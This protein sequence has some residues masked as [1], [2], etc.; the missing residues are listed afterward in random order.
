MTGEVL[1][2]TLAVILVAVIAKLV[3]CGVPT[4]L[5]GMSTRDSLVV[6][7]GMAARGE[8]AMIVALLTLSKGVL[9]QSAYVSLVI[10]SLVTLFGLAPGTAQLVVS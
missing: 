3:D 2:A 4:R 8:V 5:P 9:E 1:T 10:M 7:F 6:G